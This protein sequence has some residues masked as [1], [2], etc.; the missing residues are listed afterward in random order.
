VLIKGT[1][2]ANYQELFTNE[3]TSDLQLVQLPAWGYKV[4]VQQNK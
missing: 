1:T 3:K 2:K 4:Y